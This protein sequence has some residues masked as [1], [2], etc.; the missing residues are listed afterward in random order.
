MS[1][2][3]EFIAR[4]PAL[5]FSGFHAFSEERL[6]QVWRSR[7]FI[8]VNSQLLRPIMAQIAGSAY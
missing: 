3:A 8:P 5:N 2:S 1:A 7:G 4:N 6:M